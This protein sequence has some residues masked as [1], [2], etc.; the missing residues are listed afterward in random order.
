MRD[1]Y[2]RSDLLTPIAAEDYPGWGRHYNFDG[3]I[4]S[5]AAQSARVGSYLQVFRNGCL[6]AVEAELLRPLDGQRK[7]IIPP[8]EL[9]VGEAVGIYFELLKALGFEPP[10]FLMLSLLGVNGYEMFRRPGVLH[11][12]MSEQTIRHN[13]LIMPE[14]QID[15]YAES[16]FP[17]LKQ[18]FD[19]VWQACGWEGDPNYDEN[20]V[21]NYRDR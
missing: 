2:R 14:V 13:D 7:V 18:S 15:E 20:G 16:Y 12:P 11:R 10:I 1:V 17:F 5:V 3:V 19:V 6:E 4:A 9:R 8:Y 21:W